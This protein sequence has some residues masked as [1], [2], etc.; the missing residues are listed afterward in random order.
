MKKPDDWSLLVFLIFSITVTQ[1]YSS[2]ET[3]AVSSA[4]TRFSS[5]LYQVT[6]R[7]ARKFENVILSPSSVSTAFGMTLVGARGNTAKQLKR[8]FGLSEVRDSSVSCAIGQLSRNMEGNT[9]KSFNRM[10]IADGFRV[11]NSFQSTLLNDF[12]APAESVNFTSPGTLQSINNRVEKITNKKIVNLIPKGSFDEETKVVLISAVYFKGNWLKPFNP[13]KTRDQPFYV[14]S[15]RKP[16]VTKMMHIRG[17]FRLAHLIEADASALELPYEGHQM[18]MIILLP[19]QRDG[20]GRLES[21]LSSKNILSLLDKGF[22]RSRLNVI[23]PKFKM[24]TSL[25]LVNALKKL[26]VLDLFNLAS[27]DLSGMSGRKELFVSDAFQRAFIDVN[28]KGTEAAA[29]TVR[30]EHFWVKV[31]KINSNDS[32]R[33]VAEA[34]NLMIPLSTIDSGSKSGTDPPKPVFSHKSK[35]SLTKVKPIV[36]YRI[37]KV[38][39][40]KGGDG[41]VSLASISHNPFAGPDGGDG[42]NGGHVTFM[43][44]SNKNSLDHIPSIIKANDG[45]DGRNK[46]CHGRNASHLTISVPIGTMFKSSDGRIMADLNQEGAVFIAARGGAGGKG[47]NYF[48]SDVNQAPEVAE[49]GGV[50]EELGY[51]I[52]MRTIAHVGLIGL[53][54]AGKSTFLRAISRARPKVAP[55]PFTTLQPHVGI[56]K[57]DDLQHISVADIPGI[58]A[59]AHRNRGLGIAFLRHIERCVCLLYIVDTSM[60]APWKQLE[61]LRY[62]LEQYNSELLT[63]PSAVLANKMDIKHSE[64]NLDELKRYVAALNLPLFPISAQENLRILPVLKYIRQ[65]Y[66]DICTKNEL[67]DE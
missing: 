15:S 66:D 48:K 7:N 30:H 58:I 14:A 26:G 49:Y 10:F 62:E 46:N 42:G 11:T 54:N 63:R 59:G 9:L 12:E 32:G 23:I 5:S 2:C 18:S 20:L 67:N 50:G 56:V 6:V 17:Y 1:V 33:P 34:G 27:A 37:I 4:L 41:C 19:N 28:E 16:V 22:K 55:Y 36:D 13:K 52:E 39:G 51:I 64:S 65:L 60:P 57:Y 8:V 29:A 38:H 3:R 61:V 25:N 47:N 24:E 21:D 53:P 43:A 44:T 45:V 40:G 35:S 31:R